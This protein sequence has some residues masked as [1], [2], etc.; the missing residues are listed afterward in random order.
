MNV[1]PADSA[2]VGH[3]AS[4]DRTRCAGEIRTGRAARPRARI[5]EHRRTAWDWCR[6][7]LRKRRARGTLVCTGGGSK[8]ERC[9]RRERGDGSLHRPSFPRTTLHLPDAPLQ[10]SEAPRGEMS[11]VAPEPRE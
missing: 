2:G 4:C 11:A 3:E 9:N 6:R 5:A 1:L 7:L 8:D 10:R